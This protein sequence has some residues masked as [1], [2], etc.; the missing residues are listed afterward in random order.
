MSVNTTKVLTKLVIHTP[1]KNSTAY[2]GSAVE[3]CLPKRGHKKVLKRVV[4]VAVLRGKG[5]SPTV[6]VPKIHKI[7]ITM[8]NIKPF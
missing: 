4:M 3:A 1:H 7:P 2:S 5:K 6:P 8:I